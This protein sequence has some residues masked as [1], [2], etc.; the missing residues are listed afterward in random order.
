MA[1]STTAVLLINLAQ[2]A[3]EQGACLLNYAPV[4]RL[5]KDGTG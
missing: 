4:V 5:L 1:S 2:T 3:A